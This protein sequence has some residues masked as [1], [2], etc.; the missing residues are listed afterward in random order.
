MKIGV[1]SDTHGIFNPVL[2]GVFGD[3]DLIIHA[4]D[5]GHE[6][7]IT[8]LET[9]APVKAVHGNTDTYPLTA[10]YPST[11]VL[12]LNG[13]NCYLTHRFDANNLPDQF[14]NPEALDIQVVIYGHTHHSAWQRCGNLMLLNPGSA[15][16][17]GRGESSMCALLTIYGKYKFDVQFEK[18][19]TLK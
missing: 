2:A 5:I 3:V 19:R 8:A 9:I 4:G 17:K 1:V 10:L 13:C 16:R 14:G 6:D 11:Q 7:I 18:L 12:T 15:G